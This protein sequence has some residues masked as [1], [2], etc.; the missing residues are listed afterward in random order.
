MDDLILTAM[1][2]WMDGWMDGQLA[3]LDHLWGYTTKHLSEILIVDLGP[4]PTRFPLRLLVALSES[5]ADFF[6][7][8]PLRNYF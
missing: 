4:S 7:P 1:N 6:A 8:L 2:E 5:A 3:T